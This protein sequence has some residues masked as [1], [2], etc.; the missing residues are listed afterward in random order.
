M[1][2]NVK[3]VDSLQTRQTFDHDISLTVFDS[4]TISLEGAALD[5]CVFAGSLE[6]AILG[7]LNFEATLTGTCDC[8]M[9]HLGPLIQSSSLPHDESRVP[10]Y[11]QNSPFLHVYCHMRSIYF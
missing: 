8:H 2:Q 10:H 1:P 9:V 7:Y 4:T 11:L 3:N 6:G 5:Y